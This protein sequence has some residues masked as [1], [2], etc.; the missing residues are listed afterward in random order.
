MSERFDNFSKVVKSVIA[1][2]KIPGCGIDAVTNLIPVILICYVI[3]NAVR[4][5]DFQFR[6][7]VCMEP[8]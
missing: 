6:S 7:N 3:P 5:P 4:N 1:S 8:L 2:L